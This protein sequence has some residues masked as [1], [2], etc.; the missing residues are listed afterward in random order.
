MRWRRVRW[1]RIIRVCSGGLR[2]LF[3]LLLVVVV[4]ENGDARA[5][6]TS[7]LT[8]RTTNTTHTITSNYIL[9]CSGAHSRARAKLHIPFEPLPEYIQNEVHHVSVHIRADLR[10]FKPAT[11]LWAVS[12]RVE[13]T[14]ICY[15]RATDWVF[16]TYYDPRVTPREKFSEEV[17]RGLVDQVSCYRS[18]DNFL[19]LIP[20]PATAYHP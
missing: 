20:S 3:L 8:S 2:L 12:P 5:L 1:W 9:D 19:A 16:V 6:L 14:F 15:G 17:C 11:L 18:I 13:G 7:T 10:K 4:V